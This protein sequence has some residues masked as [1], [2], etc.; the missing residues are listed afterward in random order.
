MVTIRTRADQGNDV[1]R[2]DVQDAVSIFGY[3]LQ[4]NSQVTLFG[5][6]ISTLY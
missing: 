4:I 5:G 3:E 6:Y 2:Q 1:L